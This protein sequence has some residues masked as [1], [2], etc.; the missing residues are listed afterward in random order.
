MQWNRVLKTCIFH[1]HQLSQVHDVFHVSMLRRYRSD[2]SRILKQ[3]PIEL[4]EDL[5]YAEEPVEILARKD[6]FFKK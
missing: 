3:Q 1:T 2:A 6:K 5:S 4:K